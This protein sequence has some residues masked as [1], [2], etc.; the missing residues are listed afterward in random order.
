MTGIDKITG[1]ST[2]DAAR[3]RGAQTLDDLGELTAQWLEGAIES[4]PGTMPGYGPDEETGPL[5]PVLAAVNRSAFVTEFSQP[6]LNENGWMQRAAVSGFAA[7]GT[8]R[9][10]S[11]VAA[12]ADLM[13]TAARADGAGWGTTM[14]V[15]V[16]N[17]RETTWAGGALS[18]DEI[19]D[20]YGDCCNPVAVETLCRTWQVTL[21]DPQWARPKY[22]WSVLQSFVA[23]CSATAVHG[24]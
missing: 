13:I 4:V 5:V 21:V 1:M 12:D 3:W 17:N 6:G 16:R 19:Q 15:T 9:A 11:A 8:F 20:C 24:P 18:L 23:R 7:A 22:L 2:R 14:A 10:L